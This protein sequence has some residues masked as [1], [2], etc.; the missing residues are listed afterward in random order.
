MSKRKRPLVLQVLGKHRGAHHY[1]D[2]NLKDLHD[3]CL[4][5]LLDAQRE[6][7]NRG[8]PSGVVVHRAEWESSFGRERTAFGREHE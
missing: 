6:L 5:V 1:S 3:Y 4:L 2:R 8:T 7:E